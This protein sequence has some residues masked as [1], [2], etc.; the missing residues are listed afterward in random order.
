M[1]WTTLCLAVGLTLV[2][3]L[4]ACTE[5][6]DPDGDGNGGGSFE[7]E[8]TVSEVIPTVVTVTWSVDIEAIDDAW[9]EFG[10]DDGYGSVAP[11][12]LS[13]G[14]PYET[15]LL[16]SKPARDVHFRVAVESGGDVSTSDDH[17][18]TTG[19]VPNDLPETTTETM[20]AVDD[21]FILTSTFAVAPGAVILDRDGEYVWWYEAPSD[22]FQVARAR[23]TA[24]RQHIVFW[25]VNLAQGPDGASQA[26]QELIRVSLDG[27][28][29]VTRAVEDGHH[30]FAVMPD[31]GITYI[32]YD[33]RSG[34]EG[35]RIV[36]VSP[37][38]T[39]TEI[40]SVWDDFEYTGG[41]GPGTTFS[42]FN[43]ID[44]YEDEDAFYVSSLGLECLLK[45]D[46]ASGELLWT[47][48]GQYSDFELAN[49]STDLFERNHQFQRL[50]GSI[51]MFV[52]GDEQTNC[53][54]V[55]EY[56]YEGDG[57]E[58][59]LLWSYTPDPAVYT[60]SL[61]D[62][63]RL[64]SGNTMVTFSNQGQIDEV[65]EDGNV[66]WRLSGELGGAVGYATFMDDLHAVY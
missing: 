32:E 20:G 43:A 24:D 60:F 44:Y 52:N 66:V 25:S 14:P 49:G 21:G 35:D 8:P 56:A 15:V 59:E 42:H 34:I 45:I 47:M 58:V 36:E 28:E 6:N 65:D 55:R 46:R 30:D 7:V 16:G 9:V 23:M 31:G 17:A 19:G 40:W 38:G 57:G 22:D 18:V 54:D 3:T 27:T 4:C 51:L 33:V 48:S 41:T 37:D 61:G 2:T 1:R 62:V 13:G 63:S 10:P 5:A 26:D 29:V 11:A 53:S 39:E 64:D 50:D 12:D